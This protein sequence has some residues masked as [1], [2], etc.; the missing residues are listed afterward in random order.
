MKNDV[1]LKISTGM[2]TTDK[3]VLGTELLLNRI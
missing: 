1:M 2:F 3:T